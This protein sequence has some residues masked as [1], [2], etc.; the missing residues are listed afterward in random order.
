MLG[1]T[2]DPWKKGKTVLRGGIGL[3]YENAIFNNVLFGRPGL[4]QAGLF[5]ATP[6]LCSQNGLGNDTVPFPT[7]PVAVTPG[8]RNIKTGVCGQ[9]LGLVGSDIVALQNQYIAAVT[10]AGP[11]A[12]ANFPGNNLAPNF[13]TV[14]FYAPNYRSPYS[15]QMNVGVQRELK[16][17]MVLSADLIRNV[18]LHYLLGVD[19]NHVGDARF[20][21]KNA[22]LNAIALT[23][24][25]FPGC[26]GTTAAAITCAIAAGATIADYA[27]N[28]LDSGNAFLSG[29]PFNLIGVNPNCPGAPVPCTADVG[30]AFP[31]I[32]PFAGANTALAPIGRSVYNAL[33]LSF[34][35]N[36]SNPM[37]LV[38]HIGL[39]AS[40][41]LSR[42]KSETGDQDF[43]TTAADFA[44]PG[45]FFGPTA[46]D[47]T[48]QFSIGTTL[49]WKKG[50]RTAFLMHVRSPLPSTLSIDTVGGAE[51]FHT[52]L[53]GDGTTG[54]IVGNLGQYMRQVSPGSLNNFITNFNNKVAGTITPAGQ[55]LVDAG[56]FTSAQ[57]IA[58][59]ATVPS[60]PLAPAGQKGNDWLNQFDL[61]LSYRIHVTEKFTV[62]PGI[63]IYNLFNF[64]NF[65]TF[66]DQRVGGVLGG[67][68]DQV[69]GNATTGGNRDQFRAIQT[70]SLYG[71]GAARQAEL[72]N[73]RRGRRQKLAFQRIRTI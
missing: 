69:N 4:L 23:N 34:R 16:N 28:G 71:L 14:G 72:G 56:L 10:A 39:Q 19:T 51:I 46:F 20:L 41:A 25:A 63:S 59:G 2:W 40:Y 17:G 32:N 54:D 36:R 49:D 53:T 67:G 58:A 70:P 50:L 1:L 64:A 31:G 33:Q 65:N 55:A 27:A 57:L 30:A 43:V 11:A 18:N 6:A 9:A 24:A 60:I 48:H 29:A 8:G 7:G 13:A 61:K 15:I 66:P 38:E 47:R 26:A 68:G 44:R 12:N 22:A 45:R 62:E 52:D 3:Y 42:F 37:P 5:N 21:N 73:P 35:M